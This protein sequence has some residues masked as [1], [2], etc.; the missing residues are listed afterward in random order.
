MRYCFDPNNTVHL[1][2]DQFESLRER[3]FAVGTFLQQNLVVSLLYCSVQ[4]QNFNY[5]Y[6]VR[7]LLFLIPIA[8]RSDIARVGHRTYS[9]PAAEFQQLIRWAAE[10]GVGITPSGSAVDRR[11]FTTAPPGAGGNLLR[12]FISHHLPKVTGKH[13]RRWEEIV[14]GGP[15]AIKRFLHQYLQFVEGVCERR[16]YVADRLDNLFVELHSLGRRLVRLSFR[17]D[18][19]STRLNNSIFGSLHS[20]YGEML[21][22]PIWTACPLPSSPTER[23]QFHLL[24]VPWNVDSIPEFEDEED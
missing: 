8:L 23:Y 4:F 1:F 20:V 11:D 13:P 19:F 10:C 2:P 15:P 9:A 7:S 24:S 16:L 3:I 6:A 5:E 12:L 17:E 21:K 22:S 18:I 14:V